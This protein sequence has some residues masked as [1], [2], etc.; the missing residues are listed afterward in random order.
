MHIFISR[1][2]PLMHIFSFYLKHQSPAVGRMAI[3][4]RRGLDPNSTG[5]F[6]QIIGNARI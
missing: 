3:S 4:T 6:L 5:A 1:E 2:V